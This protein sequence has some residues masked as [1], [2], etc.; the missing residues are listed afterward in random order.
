MKTAMAVMTRSMVETRGMKG[1]RVFD[2]TGIPLH[3]DNETVVKERIYL[4]KANH[5]VLIDEVT[6]IDHALT[7]PWTVTRKYGRVKNPVWTEQICVEENHHVVIGKENYYV[8]DDGFLMPVR[9]G[10]P[11]PDLRFFDGA[12]K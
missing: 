5:D 4:D 8:S 9:K 2:S 7:R 1:P 6:T 11:A 3:R 10:Q 12:A